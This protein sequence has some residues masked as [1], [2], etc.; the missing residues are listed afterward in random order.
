MGQEDVPAGE[1]DVHEAKRMVDSDEVSVVDVRTQFPFRAM[2][3]AAYIPLED[4]LT[5]PMEVLETDKPV[6][7]I[8][9]VGQTSGVATQM[10]HA[11]GV[12][13]AYN[14]M[15]GMKAWEEAGYETEDPPADSH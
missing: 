12:A 5:R 8:C 9:N 10:A 13:N 4:I 15:G 2:A 1:V 6:L 11:M 7:F 3:G 14:M